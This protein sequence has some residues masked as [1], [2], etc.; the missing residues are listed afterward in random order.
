MII[1]PSRLR[2]PYYGSILGTRKVRPH[3]NLPGIPNALWLRSGKSYADYSILYALH[4]NTARLTH[5]TGEVHQK[6]FRLLACEASS[7]ASPETRFKKT[8]KK[9]FTP[10]VLVYVSG[11]SM[12]PVSSGD[13]DDREAATRTTPHTATLVIFVGGKWFSRQYIG[14]PALFNRHYRGVPTYCLYIYRKIVAKT[15]R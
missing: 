12:V 4:K 15:K 2:D 8:N 14:Q 3:A 1:F 6:I 10:V 7:H 11:P 5:A 13:D 9:R